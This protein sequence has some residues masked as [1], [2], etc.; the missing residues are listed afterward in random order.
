M[1][2]KNHWKIDENPP[3][4]KTSLSTGKYTVVTGKFYTVIVTCKYILVKIL[5]FKKKEWIPW[6]LKQKNKSL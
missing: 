2:K 6:A 3:E 5:D 1:Q 4:I